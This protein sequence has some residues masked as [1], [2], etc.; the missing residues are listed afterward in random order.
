M[1]SA[2]IQINL[3]TSSQPFSHPLSANHKKS[4][5]IMSSKR[6][7]IG[8]VMLSLAAATPIVVGRDEAREEI[9]ALQW[10]RHTSVQHHLKL[11]QEPHNQQLRLPLSAHQFNLATHPTFL[12]TTTSPPFPKMLRIP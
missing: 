10:L 5:V 2:A 4:I 7:A 3:L 11:V 12:S 1:A 6:I 8:A 9:G